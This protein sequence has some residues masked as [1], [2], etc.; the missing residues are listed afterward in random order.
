M[1]LVQ[2]RSR[3]SSSASQPSFLP[4]QDMLQ[5]GLQDPLQQ[6]SGYDARTDDVLASL[7][8]GAPLG[9]GYDL[10]TSAPT[11]SPP[12]I[13]VDGYHAEVDPFSDTSLSGYQNNGTSA[14]A[15]RL[16][17]SALDTSDPSADYVSPGKAERTDDDDTVVSN[18][19][20]RAWTPPVE[21]SWK[22][23][24]KGRWKD[25]GHLPDAKQRAVALD[26]TTYGN[27]EQ[28]A[29]G[30]RGTRQWDPV[31]KTPNAI[32]GHSSTRYFRGE[33][34]RASELQVKDG[35][36]QQ[37]GK[38]LDTQGASGVG[39]WG[40]RGGDRHI[41][42]MGQSTVRSAPAWDK[43]QEEVMDGPKD[44]LGRDKVHLKFVNHSSLLSGGSA[45]AAGDMRAEQGRLKLLS[46]KSGHYKPDG[47]MF[48]SALRRFVD[49]GVQP[50]GLT[51]EFGNKYGSAVGLKNG[52][53]QA[54]ALE[55]LSYGGHPQAEGFMRQARA[56]RSAVLHGVRNHHPIGFRH[57]TTHDRS[58]VQNPGKVVPGDKGVVPEKQRSVAA[59]RKRFQG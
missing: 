42:A 2:A 19:P 32:V 22:R 11:V 26:P 47:Q 55:A 7:K 51:A 58:G 17:W 25:T 13:G 36:L 38:L 31:L 9:P 28:D 45:T 21:T 18:E 30:F 35:L 53:L 50:E 5:E 1:T 57:A 12:D 15:P 20:T 6:L 34:A 33:E 48:H 44:V 10:Q 4:N 29:T 14:E 43:H 23:E 46:D 49:H 56:D 16:A 27:E 52:D 59:L 24:G 37:G 54:S 39:T 41:Y 40:S 3:T 8:T